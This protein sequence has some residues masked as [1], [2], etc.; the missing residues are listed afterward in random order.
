M[1]EQK[2]SNDCPPTTGSPAPQP[3]PPGDCGSDGT[4]PTSTPPT[5]EDPPKC[6]PTDCCCPPTPGTTANCLEDLI[7]AQTASIAAAQNTVA[8]RDALNKLLDGAK[9]ASQDY[10]RDKYDA[11]VKLW[12]DEDA[13]I[14]ELIRRLVC[15]VPCWTCVIECHVCPLIDQIVM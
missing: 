3:H 4:Y 11:L 9:K 14:V 5:V 1:S 12:V 7:A 8:F 15:V 2:R 6:P 10:T 13:V